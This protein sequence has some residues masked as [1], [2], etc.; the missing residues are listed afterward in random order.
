M[1]GSLFGAFC[2]TMIVVAIFQDWLLCGILAGVYILLVVFVVACQYVIW[3]K[4]G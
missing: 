4:K 1:F 3:N 2:A